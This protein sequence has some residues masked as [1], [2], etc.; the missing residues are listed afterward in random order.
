MKKWFYGIYGIE[1][2]WHG[3]WS[4]PELIWHKRSF[5]YYDVETPLWGV[6]S[7]ECNKKG[8]PPD[9]YF[10]GDWVK[11]NANLARVYLQN[12]MDCKCFYGGETA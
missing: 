4:D 10:F 5:N 12:L 9:E 2:I 6:Y 11:R 3:E 8:R 7:E 1:F